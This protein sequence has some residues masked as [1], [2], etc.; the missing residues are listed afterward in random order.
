MCEKGLQVG[1]VALCV[2]GASLSEPHTDELY[3]PLSLCIYATVNV[4][5]KAMTDP[6]QVWLGWL[7]L[8][9]KC[10]CCELEEWPKSNVG[11]KVLTDSNKVSWVCMRCYIL[12]V[13]TAIASL[14]PLLGDYHL[15]VVSTVLALVYVRHA[16]HLQA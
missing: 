2:I 6:H 14:W 1:C 3:A 13:I 11:D 4:V 9:E 16:S 10:H 12:E 7:G 15:Y 5:Y 8:N